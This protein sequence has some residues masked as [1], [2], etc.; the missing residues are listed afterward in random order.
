MQRRTI[1]TKCLIA[2]VT[3]FLLAGIGAP[4]VRA[5]MSAGR[6]TA[7]AM[8]PQN[9]QKMRFYF[10]MGNSDLVFQYGPNLMQRQQFDSLAR[11]VAQLRTIRIDSVVMTAYTS[12]TDSRIGSRELAE[13]RIVAVKD[14]ILRTLEHND[15]R[16]VVLMS[17]V[18]SA[19]D[20]D[21][22]AED[23]DDPWLA[24]DDE[25]N[26]VRRVEFTAYL[27]AGMGSARAVA[28]N[29]TP[30]LTETMADT[31]T[32]AQRERQLA[33][34]ATNPYP[35]W[36]PGAKK[37]VKS[38]AVRGRGYTGP[39][40]QF[41]A[42]RTNLPYWLVA[43]PNAGVE[44]YIGGRFS[45]LLEGTLSYW[46]KKTDTGDK[47]IY[48]AGGGPEF[49]YWFNDDRSKS[50]HLIGIYG[51]YAD[52]D[53][54]LNETG[55]QGTAIGGGISYGYYMPV[56]RRW[57]FEFGIGIGYLNNKMDVY[58]W[59]PV[60]NKNLWVEEET[61]AWIGPTKVKAAVIF[62]IGNKNY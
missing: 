36:V 4:D 32:D 35:V 39:V 48:L 29:V 1:Y 49:R 7:E 24:G 28:I 26:K 40:N 8:Q 55:R 2:A 33:A 61:K 27:N 59:N 34:I 58:R 6:G 15:L 5:Q 17:H 21:E 56:G 10:V 25:Y 18:R 3:A 60:V 57:A 23:S 42:V 53:I 30:Q 31:I 12:P 38:Y 41:F 44:F 46:N 19:A 37:T 14:Y 20:S 52:F 16:G 54:K 13:A 62:R 22:L 43:A 51:Q 50:S 11:R 45:I 47:G 9:S